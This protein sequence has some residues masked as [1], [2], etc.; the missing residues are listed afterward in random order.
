MIW[1]STEVL[2]TIKFKSGVSL[3]LFNIKFKGNEN[4]ETEGQ[5]DNV[6]NQADAF[7]AEWLTRQCS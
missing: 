6:T 5:V 1:I 4:E 3:I 7:N 2:L